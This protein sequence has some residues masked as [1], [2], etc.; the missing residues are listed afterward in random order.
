MKRIHGLMTGMMLGVAAASLY[1]MM[2]PRAQRRI[3]RGAA[4][5]GRRAARF[6]GDLFRR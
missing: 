4:M 2:G 3:A 1:G 5:A 6:A